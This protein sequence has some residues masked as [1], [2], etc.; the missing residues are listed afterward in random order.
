MSSELTS[1]VTTP[2]SG[3]SLLLTQSLLEAANTGRRGGDCSLYSCT[4]QYELADLTATP[5]KP[6][7]V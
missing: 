7:D 2:L 5:E 6:N 4:E 3:S 1:D